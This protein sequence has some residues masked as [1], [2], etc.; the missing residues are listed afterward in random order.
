VAHQRFEFR[1]VQDALCA[2]DGLIVAEAAGPFGQRTSVFARSP[3]QG[4]VDEARTHFQVDRRDLLGG[5]AFLKVPVPG[6]E[7]VHPTDYGVVIDARPFHLEFARP[8]VVMVRH[9]R[10]FLPRGLGP[11]FPAVLQG[12]CEGHGG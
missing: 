6:E 10:R 2:S 7:V 8:V 1:I 11:G 5:H 12:K 9:E 3:G 4:D